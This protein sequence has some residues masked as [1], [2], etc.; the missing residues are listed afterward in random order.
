MSELCFQLAPPLWYVKVDT[1]Q[2]VDT[3]KQWLRKTF[4]F[5]R[6]QKNSAHYN[7]GIDTSNKATWEESMDALVTR[8]LAVLR[9][10]QL[11]KSGDNENEL[12]LTD[13]GEIMSVSIVLTWFDYDLADWLF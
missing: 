3:A 13:F 12:V 1:I 6:I 9:D 10:T 7:V 11:V 5:R 4:L 2:S 8:S